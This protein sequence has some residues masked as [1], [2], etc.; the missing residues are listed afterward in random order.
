MTISQARNEVDH[1]SKKRGVII[2]HELT[3]DIGKNEAEAVKCSNDYFDVVKQATTK[4]EKVIVSLG[5]SRK[6]DETKH[7]LT[8]MINWSLKGR[9]QGNQDILVCE[10]DNMLY[11]GKPNINF[12]GRDGYHLSTLGKVIFSQNLVQCIHKA[13]GLSSPRLQVLEDGWQAQ[14]YKQRKN[15][16]GYN[17]QYNNGY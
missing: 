9:L 16:R 4:A 8:Q 10:H 17:S 15:N 7:Q 12:L 6:D 2:I 3:N 14:G 13:T 1:I 5:L 11:Y